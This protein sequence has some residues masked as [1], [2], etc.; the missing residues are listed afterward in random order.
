V[1]DGIGELWFESDE[2]LQTA[3]GLPRMAAAVE[4]ARNFFDMDRTGPVIVDEKTPIG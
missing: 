3:L 4:D 2:V 1:C